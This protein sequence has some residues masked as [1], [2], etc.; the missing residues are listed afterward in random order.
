MFS[1]TLYIISTI[2]KHSNARAQL[3]FAELCGPPIGNGGYHIGVSRCSSCY[4]VFLLFKTF[5]VRNQFEM[6]LKQFEMNLKCVSNTTF[7]CSVKNPLKP[8]FS[9]GGSHVKNNIYLPLLCQLF[10]PSSD[11]KLAVVSKI[12]AWTPTEQMLL[13]SLCSYVTF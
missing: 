9:Y 7:R 12:P 11:Q 4:Q 5:S 1:L 8:T 13:Q 3:L 6:H 2:F 10:Q